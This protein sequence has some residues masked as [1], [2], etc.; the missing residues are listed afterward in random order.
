MWAL[1]ALLALLLVITLVSITDQVEAGSAPKDLSTSNTPT[2]KGEAALS[3]TRDF[4]SIFNVHYSA[5]F[6]QRIQLAYVSTGEKAETA[7]TIVVN[8]KGQ[9]L[10]GAH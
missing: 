10:H 9:A 2:A 5:K 3:D 7:I 1:K 8:D 4:G 6:A